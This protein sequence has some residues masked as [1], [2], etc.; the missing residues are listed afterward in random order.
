MVGMELCIRPSGYRIGLYPASLSE[1]VVAQYKK[2]R[3]CFMS[4]WSV[5]SQLSG[6]G[7]TEL[8]GS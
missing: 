8:P 7:S 4:P 5:A 6:I 2:R 1:Y 3:L